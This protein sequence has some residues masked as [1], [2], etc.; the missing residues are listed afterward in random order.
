MKKLGSSGHEKIRI[1]TIGFT[2]KTARQFF[3]KLKEA[4]LNIAGK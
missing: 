3:T 4:A 1:F 2:G